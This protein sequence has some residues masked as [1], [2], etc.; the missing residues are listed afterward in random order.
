MKMWWILF[1]GDVARR[2]CFNFYLNSVAANSIPLLNFSFEHAMYT[3]VTLKILE[4]YKIVQQQITIHSS[5]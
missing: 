2:T 5:M 1:V 4:I 3:N